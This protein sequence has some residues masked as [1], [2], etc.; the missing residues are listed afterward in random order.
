MDYYNKPR[1]FWRGGPM[2]NFHIAL[3]HRASSTFWHVATTPRTACKH[4]LSS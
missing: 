3:F 4:R 1:Y 2:R